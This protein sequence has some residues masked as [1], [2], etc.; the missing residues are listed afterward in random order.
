[1]P[2]RQAKRLPI[3][4]PIHVTIARTNAAETEKLEPAF[5]PSRQLSGTVCFEIK[6]PRHTLEYSEGVRWCKKRAAIRRNQAVNRLWYYGR[7]GS[8]EIVPKGASKG[9]NGAMPLVPERIPA[10]NNGPEPSISR[11]AKRDIFRWRF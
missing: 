5:D 2:A 6:R 8:K 9:S 11:A 10:Y 4:Q 7:T 1:M 3:R